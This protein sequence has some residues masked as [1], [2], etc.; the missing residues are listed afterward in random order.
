[1]VVASVRLKSLLPRLANNASSGNTVTKSSDVALRVMSRPP[2]VDDDGKQDKDGMG[3]PNNVGG[4]YKRNLKAQSVHTFDHADPRGGPRQIVP[5]F[6][7]RSTQRTATGRSIIRSRHRGQRTS[8]STSNGF[9]L[10]S[11]RAIT[12]LQLKIGV[13]IL[14]LCRR[15]QRLRLHGEM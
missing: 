15:I 5:A 2:D 14:I 9:Q 1:M 11:T 13:L 4:G 3:P 12:T 8:T 10:A 7:G 6:S